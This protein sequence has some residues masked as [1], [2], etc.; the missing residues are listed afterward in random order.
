MAAFH[1]RRRAFTLIELL[2]VIAIIAILAAILFPVFAQAREQARAITCLSNMKQIGTALRMYSQDYGETM[3]WTSNWN[4]GCVSYLGYPPKYDKTGDLA[5]SQ[6]E[7]LLNPYIKSARLWICPSWDEARIALFMPAVCPGSKVTAAQ[8]H[9][10]Y[11]WVHWTYPGDGPQGSGIKVAG[12]A[13]PGTLGGNLPI[14]GRS[15]AAVVAPSLAPVFWD[16]ADYNSPP[17]NMFPPH[18]SGINACYLDGHA[19]VSTS[20][21]SGQEWYQMHSSDGWVRDFMGDGMHP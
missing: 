1:R 17:Q 19:K 10:S 6:I 3:P 14:A 12:P 4:S 15:E 11:Y 13:G 7:V 8:V 18:P 20:R 9:S 5:G 2:V 16:W 21:T